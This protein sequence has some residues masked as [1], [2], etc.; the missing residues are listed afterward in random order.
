M[1]KIFAMDKEE[2]ALFEFIAED[3]AFA[4]HHLEV[5]KE[6]RHAE[7]IKAAQAA[8][9]AIR[10]EE[11][12]Q[13]RERIV[14]VEESVRKELAQRLHGEVQNKL[15]VV[16]H[17]LRELQHQLSDEKQAGDAHQLY[18]TL[19][20]ILEKNIRPISHRLFPSILRRGLTP[21]LQ[22]LGDQLENRMQVE[23]QVDEALMRQE[24]ETPSFIPEPVRL[25]TYRIAEEALTNVAK[26][27]QASKVSIT[28]NLVDS[29][30]HLTIKDNGQGFDIDSSSGKFGLMIM[31][32]YAKVL[33]GTCAIRSIT[34]QGTEVTAA[35]PLAAPGAGSPS[36]T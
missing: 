20:E 27:S 29:W 35:L 18:Q 9:L 3:I 1:S 21:A 11:L 31:E 25:A 4:L 5:E 10:A 13:S 19:Q 30:L 34:G 14:T 33:G 17:R 32:D 26:Y 6:R 22:S 15:I 36:S 8:I 28:Q 2:Q 7:E 23:M 16:L 24:R 12:Q